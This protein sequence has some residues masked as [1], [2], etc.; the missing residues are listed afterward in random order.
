[1]VRFL[2]SRSGTAAVAIANFGNFGDFGNC[3]IRVIRVIRG[4]FL[5]P[6]LGDHARSRR[7][8]RSRRCLPTPSPGFDPIRPQPTQ[9]DPMLRTSAEGHSPKTQEPGLSR[10]QIHYVGTLARHSCLCRCLWTAGRAPRKALFWLYG[11]EAPANVAS[12]SHAN[13]I[14][15][16]CIT[17]SVNR[18]KKFATL[19]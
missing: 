6:D 12:I 3:P 18:N 1:M 17:V 4:K 13:K 11:T 15:T 5:V 10:V 16:Y 14:R 9:I 19:C 2:L 8:R 7:C